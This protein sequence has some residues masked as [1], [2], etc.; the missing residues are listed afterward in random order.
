MG[1]VLH[2][3]LMQPFTV[4]VLGNCCQPGALKKGFKVGLLELQGTWS[5]GQP[6]LKAG[7]SEHGPNPRAHQDDGRFLKY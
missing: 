3:I 1:P 7:Q 4:Q 2:P 6:S 5:I